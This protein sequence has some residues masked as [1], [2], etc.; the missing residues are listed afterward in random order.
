MQ[1]PLPKN[2]PNSIIIPIDITNFSQVIAIGLF[3]TAFVFMAR[4][5]P[6]HQN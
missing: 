1:V 5:I 3:A 6:Q 2:D 4:T